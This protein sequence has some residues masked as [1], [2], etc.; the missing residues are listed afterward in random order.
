MEEGAGVKMKMPIISDVMTDIQSAR[1][2][3]YADGYN[4]GVKSM[5]KEF[6]ELLE[7]AERFSSDLGMYCTDVDRPIE[8]EF[9]SWKK[10]RGIK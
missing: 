3:G 7:M 1:M 5:E 6:R 2:G 8:G 10:A 9:I 4:D